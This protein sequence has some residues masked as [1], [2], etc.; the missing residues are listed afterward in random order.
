MGHLT[1]QL[2]VAMAAADSADTVLFSLSPGLPAVLE[3]GIRGEYCPSRERRWIPEARWNG[4]LRHRLLAIA[5]EV[6]P[7][8]LVFDGVAPYHGILASRPL[9]PDTAFVWMRRG[10]WRPGTNEAQLRR[11]AIFDQVIEP[12]DLA[13]AADRGATAGR[14]D[15]IVVPPV[16]MLEVVEPLPRAEAAAAL[17]IDPSRPT[18]LVTLGTGRLSDVA[19]PGEV[20][21]S[22]LLENPDWQVCL[23]KAHIATAGLRVVDPERIVELRGVYPL[24]RYLGAFD[25]VVSAVGYNSVHEFIPAALP[26][27]FVPSPATD[28]TTDDQYARADWI[29]RNG[30]GL[31]VRAEDTAGLVA[32]ARA[33]SDRGRRAELAERCREHGA[34]VG[35][36]AATAGILSE[37][38]RAFRPSPMLRIKDRFRTLDLL[39]REGIK[40]MLG[41]TGTDIVRRLRRRS[42]LE[43]AAQE[44]EVKV[45][46]HLEAAGAGPPAALLLSEEVDADTV[47]R[48]EPVE[49]LL[50][51]SSPAYRAARL[52][53]I[54]R[55]YR[56]VG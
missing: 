55:F 48:T 29:G 44:L 31:A 12:G 3:P 30:L 11:G 33:L 36:A 9:L 46:D 7:D 2:T 45:V 41:P 26:T 27:L 19:G 39:A 5:E 56:V 49:H 14:S 47:R 28:L 13:G 6:A 22:T 32:A 53:V 52:D 54:R 23:T 15:A 17:G 25:A 10:M 38:A 51:G 24:V 43:G 21:L 37:L 18:V 20:V 8:V 34:A 35:G 16:S 40:E 50:A 1:R 4:Y 42:I